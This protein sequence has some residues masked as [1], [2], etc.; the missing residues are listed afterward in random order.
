MLRFKSPN[1]RCDSLAQPFNS[2]EW[3]R[4]NFSLLYLYITMQT[5]DENKEKY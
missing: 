5:S 4:Q 3:P 2:S 1:K